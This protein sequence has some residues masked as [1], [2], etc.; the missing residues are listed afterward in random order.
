MTLYVLVKAKK[1]Y[2]LYFL[3]Y[4]YTSLKTIIVKNKM[5]YQCFFEGPR[6]WILLSTL[7]TISLTRTLFR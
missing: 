3:K 6:A 1:G 4:S 2:Y 7:A 5:E